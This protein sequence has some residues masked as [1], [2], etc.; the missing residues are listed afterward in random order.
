MK[1]II[2]GNSDVEGQTA[3]V[4]TAVSAK[5]EL[6]VV[7]VCLDHVSSVIVNADHGIITAARWGRW[8][9]RV[10]TRFQ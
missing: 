1:L 9:H 10:L 6:A 2:A 8:L 7:L 4:V 5:I 3:I